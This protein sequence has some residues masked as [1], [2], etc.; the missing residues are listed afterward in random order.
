MSIVVDFTN[1][2]DVVWYYQNVP[3]YS[4]YGVYQALQTFPPAAMATYLAWITANSAA[5]I[6]DYGY[7]D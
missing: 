4:R 3:D 5:S 6:E 7:S 1:E 2:A